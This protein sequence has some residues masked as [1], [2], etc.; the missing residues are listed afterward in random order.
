MNCSFLVFV[1]FIVIVGVQTED[2]IDTTCD[3]GK[4]CEEDP[5][6]PERILNSL[7]L[8]KYNFALSPVVPRVK[9]SIT[10]DS[11]LIET[12][13]CES[14][15]TFMR[16]QKLKNTNSKL[17]TIV[18]HSNFSQLVRFETCSSENFPCTFD[19]YP[20]SI[21]SF[22]QQKHRSVQLLAFDDLQNCLVT[23]KF[24]IP[25]SCECL[26]HK[27]DLFKGINSDLLRRPWSFNKVLNIQTSII[28]TSF[29]FR[30]N[31]WWVKT[32]ADD[33]PMNHSVTWKSHAILKNAS[34]FGSLGSLVFSHLQHLSQHYLNQSSLSRISSVIIQP[35]KRREPKLFR[36]F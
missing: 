33:V 34:G 9:R 14:K 31:V 18:N 16:P 28:T 7:D 6:Y 2:E 13:L 4:F 10:A 36:F 30:F 11:F 3:T 1:I 22:C 25:S 27:E 32:Q 20:K 5:N 19:I 17:R 23:E 26:I 8:W 15:I 21:K 35:F 24:L 29:S 12:K